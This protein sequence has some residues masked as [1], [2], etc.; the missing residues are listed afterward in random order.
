MPGRIAR[1]LGSRAPPFLPH[2]H[3]HP[4]GPRRATQ[5]AIMPPGG[6]EVLREP[7]VR[8]RAVAGLGL[9]SQRAPETRGLRQA[10][11]LCG[12]QVGRG[13]LTGR[14]ARGSSRQVWAG[15]A[16]LPESPTRLGGW[17]RGSG[18][19]PW[20]Y[21]SQAPSPPPLGASGPHKRW[22]PCFWSGAGHEESCQVAW[23]AGGPGPWGSGSPLW[24]FPQTH[25]FG[26]LPSPSQHHCHSAHRKQTETSW[27]QS[28]ETCP[29]GQTSH[30]PGNAFYV[31]ILL[32]SSPR[33]QRAP[34]LRCLPAPVATAW[35][36]RPDSRPAPYKTRWGRQL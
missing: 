26:T 34:S 12:A 33:Q 32:T 11:S 20:P 24:L 19:R 18:V 22:R 35:M 25:G 13:R 17:A 1:V 23:D 29:W 30:K 8:G 31:Q 9:W 14:T 36:R 15:P 5:A 3:T 6:R 27:A 2:A 21:S 10:I 16:P 4:G 7:L 28:K